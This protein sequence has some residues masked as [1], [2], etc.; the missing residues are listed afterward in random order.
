[1]K[2]GALQIVM[3]AICQN[4]ALIIVN[5]EGRSHDLS[6]VI[7][8][9]ILKRNTDRI[10]RI[11]EQER[12]LIEIGPYLSFIGCVVIE[13][14]IWNQREK[15]KYFGTEFIHVGVILQSPLPKD[16]LV[17]AEPLIMARYGFDNSTWSSRWFEIWAFK[18]PN[19]I[20]SFQGFS[21][22]AKLQVYAREPWRQLRTLLLFRAR[23]YFSIKEYHDWIESRLDSSWRKLATRLLAKI[24]GI[25]ANYLAI[26]YYSTKGPDACHLLFDLRDS[27]FY[28]RR[29]F[30]QT[31]SSDIRICTN[32]KRF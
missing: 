13:R 3:H 27:R 17:I 29:R 10:Y 19:L 30:K 9:K 20:W 32:H 4:Y 16:T 18:W 12:F 15:E 26:V 1:M 24:P 11:S 23:G 7:E 21:D 25:I 14:K 2:S 28:Y 6:M 22:S 31:A 5:A 8:I